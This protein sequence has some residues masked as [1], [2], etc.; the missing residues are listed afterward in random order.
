MALS[1]QR[2]GSLV[3]LPAALVAILIPLSCDSPTKVGRKSSAPMRK[4]DFVKLEVGQES[5]YLG[6]V[7]EEYRIRQNLRFEYSGDTLVVEVIADTDSGFV[8]KDYLTPGS[9]SRRGEG[10]IIR[11]DSVYHYMVRIVDDILEVGPY[12]SRYY[13]TRLFMYYYG[14]LPMNQIEGVKAEIISWV[15]SIPYCECYR[16]GHVLKYRQLGNYYD[17][18]NLLIDDQPMQIDANGHTFLYSKK[19][20]FVRTSTAS[21][22]TQQGIGWDLL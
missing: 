3:L 20:G 15:T 7:G 11:P 18:L 16:E 17:R 6:F 21:W 14:T 13:S 4:I 10:P 19:W 5:R 9:A 22:W 12:E 8:F 2:T 1:A